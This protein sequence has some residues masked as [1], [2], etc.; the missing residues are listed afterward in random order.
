MRPVTPI[1]LIGAGRLGGALVRGWLA[2]KAFEA[3]EL[4]IV[5]PRAGPEAIEAAGQGAVLNPGGDALKAARTVVLA[6]KP[7]LWR[8]VTEGLVD[9]LDLE[10]V[11]V[12][13]VAGVRTADLAAVFGS[14]AIARTLPSTAVAIGQGSAAVYAKSGDAL[15]VAHSVLDPVA[16]AVDLDDEELMDAG[17]GISGS[18][19]GFFYAFVEALEAAGV[20]QGL[21]PEAARGLARSGIAGAAA[22]MT[23]TGEEPSE[24]RAAVTSPA[25][26]TQAGLDVLMADG[27]LTDLLK[28]AAAAAA[29]RAKELGS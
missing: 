21:S 20:A 18:A 16:T 14:R 13:V 22:L 4:I 27:G 19:P 26:T 15:A 9:K 12:S 10:A 23:E 11:V 17:I 1:L 6:V 5:D 29:R 25:G 7:Q 24:L 8:G 3:S 28:G 2:T